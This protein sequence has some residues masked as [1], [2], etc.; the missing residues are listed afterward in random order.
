MPF[1]I[2]DFSTNQKHTY[3]FLLV[4]NTNLA[5]ILHRFRDMADY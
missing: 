4:N 3:D 5:P 1:K 2:T